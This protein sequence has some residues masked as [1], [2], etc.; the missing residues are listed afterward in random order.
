[1]PPG[2]SID[3]RW[4]DAFDT[5]VEATGAESGFSTARGIV[6]PGG[7]IVLKSTFARPM[8]AFDSSGLVVDE[9]SVVGSRCGPFAPALR[10]LAR[11]QIDVEALV[12]ARFALDDA[13]EA[14]DYASRR[15]VLKVLIQP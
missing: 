1:M 6:R 4:A 10:I 8:T 2:T 5:V 9:V 12:H 7:V 13:M 15:G 14:L 11:G 3:A